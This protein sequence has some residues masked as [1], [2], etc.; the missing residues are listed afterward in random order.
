M[1]R[2]TLAMLAGLLL[3]TVGA[4][5]VLAAAP[6]NDGFAGATPIPSLPAT[7]A[8]DLTDA[9]L[10][11]D[12]QYCGGGSASV[13][14]AYTPSSVEFV[15]AQ[16]GADPG[17]M[18][19]AVDGPYGFIDCVYAGGTRTFTAEP[20]HTY[21]LQV[22][23]DGGPTT[24]TLSSSAPVANDRFDDATPIGDLSATVSPDLT[25]STSVGDNNSCSSTGNGAWYAYTPDADVVVD[26]TSDSVQ[27]AVVTVTGAT[28]AD[29]ISCAYSWNGTLRLTLEAGTAYHFLVAAN[30]PSASG[31][32]MSIT[33]V[34]PPP[35]PPANDAKADAVVITGLPFDVTADLTSAS[36]ESDVVGYCLVD[37][38][39]VWYRY[40]PTIDQVLHL[41]VGGG[42]D[43]ARA[44]FYF[45][46]GADED[47]IAGCTAQEGGGQVLARAGITYFIALGAPSWADPTVTLRVTATPAPTV[48]FA[49]NTNGGLEKVSGTAIIT[50]KATCSSSG[51]AQLRLA[52]RQRLGRTNIVSG[53]GSAAV[54]CTPAGAP[55]SIRVPGDGKPFGSGAVS[56][57]FDGNFGSWPI[58]AV[59]GGTITVKL[60]GK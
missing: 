15:T 16:L 40:T 22:A 28:Q 39:T 1:K 21:Y 10:T 30:Y 2:R 36:S 38:R 5:P 12:P 42:S 32:A 43:Q 23:T 26:I 51:S 8:V 35:P 14:Y 60:R 27:S 37:D 47:G 31:T 44:A 7:L 48:K 33:V 55:W 45:S 19:L 11:D 9:T 24:V 59:D 29:L 41:T 6:P 3:L 18:Q 4:S 50:G 54:P 58:I 53:F 57:E 13:W 49:V 56:V 25:R 20:G 17:A 46:P 34:P 52:L